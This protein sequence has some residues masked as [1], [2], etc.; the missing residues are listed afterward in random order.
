MDYTQLHCLN[1]GGSRFTIHHVHT[2]LTCEKWLIAI[3]LSEIGTLIRNS[4]LVWLVASSFEIK[5]NTHGLIQPL[6]VLCE[7]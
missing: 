2:L 3:L 7:K 5:E 1:V 6:S 4:I